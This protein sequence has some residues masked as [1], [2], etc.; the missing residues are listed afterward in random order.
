MRTVLFFFLLSFQTIIINA[1]SYS[2]EEPV[3]TTNAANTAR[4]LNTLDYWDTETLA[5]AL[6]LNEEDGTPR[7]PD[8][9]LGHDAVVLFY[10]QWCHNCHSMAPMF[11]RVSEVM[12]AGTKKANF[13]MSLFD[14]ESSPE[15]AKLCSV[16]GVTHYPTIMFI[17]SGPL[18]DSDAVTSMV[19][20]SKDRA[21]GPA[22]HA[23][24]KRTMKFQGDWRYG[25]QIRDWIYAMKGLSTWHKVTH[26]GLLR[27]IRNGFNRQGALKNG[28][29]LSNALPVGVSNSSGGSNPALERELKSVQRD[30]DTCNKESELLAKS[31]LH[32]D[33]IVNTMLFG[34]TT[35]SE[36]DPYVYLND[37][38]GWDESSTSDPLSDVS[39]VRSCA[40][41]VSIDFCSRVARKIPDEKFENV[42]LFEIDTILYE[43]LGE[44]DPFCGSIDKCAKDDFSS[45]DCQPESCPFASQGGC[46][47]LT[48]CMNTSI[49]STYRD[50]IREATTSE[51]SSEEA[52]DKESTTT[53]KSAWGIA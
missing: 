4:R 13:V 10:A 29:K 34:D 8:T 46:L 19:M 5:Y 7:N 41:D 26:S 11:Q 9:Y 17:G 22:G 31:A 24:L 27:W 51:F 14:C 21:A 42:S 32:A 49:Q 36:Q 23:P 28:E 50:A 44:I 1:V 16:A 52:N 47:Y 20:G 18:H 39:I 35:S 25:E 3:Q 43:M 40:I 2:Q 37:N 48:S 33:D 15:A 30:L 6:G 12:E 53:K 45:L 38:K